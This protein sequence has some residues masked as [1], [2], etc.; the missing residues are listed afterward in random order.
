MRVQAIDGETM[1]KAVLGV[2]TM[3]NSADKNVEV[4]MSQQE[5]YVLDSILRPLKPK[6]A[7][8]IGSAA[9][10]SAFLMAPHVEKLYCVDQWIDY[11][12]EA[13]F[14]EPCTIYYGGDKFIGPTVEDRFFKFCHNV[15]E[16]LF[17]KTFPC[18]GSSAMW[19]KVWKTPIDFL[20]I[21]GCHSYEAVKA[22]IEG[23]YPH[24]RDGGVI[25]GHDYRT[26]SSGLDGFIWEFPGVAKAVNEFFDDVIVIPFTTFWMVTK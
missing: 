3:I 12:D 26:K 15:N 1:K 4:L 6:V 10:G 14:D 11:T 24:V 16:D 21:D 20:F 22:D 23:W 13:G 8:E 2:C 17:D 25:L 5:A 7:V 18:V 19:A 9:G